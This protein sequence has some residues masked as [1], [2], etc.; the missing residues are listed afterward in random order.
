MDTLYVNVA[1]ASETEQ[2][3]RAINE[4]VSQGLVSEKSVNKALQDDTPLEVNAGMYFQKATEETANA[5]MDYTTMTKDGLTMKDIKEERERLNARYQEFEDERSIK[6]SQAIEEILA[7]FGTEEGQKETLASILHEG[8]E[9]VEYTYREKVKETEQ[10][11][12][13]LTPIDGEEN[14]D[15]EDLQKRIKALKE[16]KPTIDKIKKSD[17]NARISLSRESF[18][19]VYEPFV[20]GLKETNEEVAQGARDSAFLLAKMVDRLS[21][22]YH[23]PVTRLMPT[24]NGHMIESENVLH[25]TTTAQEKLDRDIAKWE[26]TIDKLKDNKPLNNTI[27]VMHTPLSLQMLGA[28]SLPLVIKTSKIKK[29]L[30]THPEM[31]LDVFKQIPKAL[32]NPIMILDSATVKGRLVV[33][34]ELTGTN[35]VNVVVPCELNTE[36]ERIDVN[37]IN[38]AYTKHKNEK[39]N[40]DNFDKLMTSWFRN[41]IEKGNLRY[42]DKTRADMLLQL[43]Q[44]KTTAFLQSAGLYLPLEYKK[45]GSSYKITI[46]D[47][48]DLVKYKENNS[49][50]YQKGNKITLNKDSL[51]VYDVMQ[52]KRALTKMGSKSERLQITSNPD[53][54]SKRALSEITI[55]EMLAGIKDMDNTLIIKRKIKSLLIK[56]A[57]GFLMSL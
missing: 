33:A 31:T 18:K 54:M 22:D 20:R 47:E 43:G 24:L 26:E 35:G 41:E 14:G 36:K 50:Y 48:T 19:N 15:Y 32:T 56:I 16:L 49:F 37:L 46:L 8:L 34:L 44:Q 6:E 10:A 13:D 30:K 42:V 5:M 1:Q 25:Q 39:R 7:T 21:Q 27:P 23:I 9:H 3:R 55:H 2:G 17:I 38:S 57:S 45:N 11:L 53:L 28:K 29:I 4:L 12:E 52:E 51:V 40:P